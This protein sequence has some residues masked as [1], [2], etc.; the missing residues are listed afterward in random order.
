[1]WGWLVA[2][3]LLNV[4]LYI[5]IR[6]VK[7]VLRVFGLIDRPARRSNVPPPQGPNAKYLLPSGTFPNHSWPSG[8]FPNHSL[9]KDELTR[10]QVDAAPS[11][12]TVPTTEQVS[13]TI[14]TVNERIKGE[15][16]EGHLVPES[17]S[18]KRFAVTLQRFLFDELY[19]LGSV[20]IS[21]V[22]SPITSDEDLKNG[23]FEAAYCARYAQ[24]DT[25]AVESG[26]IRV[27]FQPNP[28]AIYE[29]GE[30]SS[31]NLS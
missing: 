14:E 11:F 16:E 9:P 26:V 25:E 6:F 8:K 29:A 19:E 31:S 28:Q 12:L 17:V 7:G 22:V 27:N 4:A 3:V 5:L 30:P 21:L 10:H 1:M 20:L 2:T 13:R 18:V 23:L 24:V 15:M